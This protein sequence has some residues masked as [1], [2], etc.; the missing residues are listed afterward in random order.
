MKEPIDRKELK[1]AMDGYFGRL[2]RM[3]K[4]LRNGETAIFLDLMAIVDKQPT[5][6]AEPVRHGKWISGNPI[7]PC[8]GGDKFKDLDA[9]IWADWQPKYCPNCGARMDAERREE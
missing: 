5:V 2:Q 1:K 8:C 7:C 3:H 9:D 6:E 4:R